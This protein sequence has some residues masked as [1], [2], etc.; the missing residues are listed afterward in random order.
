MCVACACVL[1]FPP[2]HHQLRAALGVDVLDVGVVTCREDAITAQESVVEE[3][4]VGGCWVGF[5]DDFIVVDANSSAVV[6]PRVV[7]R[8]SCGCP[9][10]ASTF[11]TIFRDIPCTP[12]TCLN[13]GRCLST[14]SGTR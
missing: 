11:S 8:G 9:A 13:G 2:R 5:A 6:G 14:S 1:I 7:L 3:R 4:C 10:G 12:H